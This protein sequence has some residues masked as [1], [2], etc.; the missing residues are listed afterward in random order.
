MFWQDETFVECAF[1]FSLVQFSL[2]PKRAGIGF[3][4]LFSIK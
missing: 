1:W 2:R 3:K 4:V